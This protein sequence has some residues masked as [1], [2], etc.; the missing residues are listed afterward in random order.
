MNGIFDTH[1][2]YHDAAFDGDR[3]KLLD[4]F[5]E[6]GILGVINCGTD[7]ETSKESLSLSREYPFM[8]AA[9]G[10]HPED[11]EKAYDGYTEDLAVLLAN[12]RAVA[13]GEI[14]LDYHFRD[15][16]KEE[17]KKIFREQ[18]LLANSLGLPVIVHARDAYADTYSILKELRPKGVMHCF[19]GS[20]ESAEEI[21][22]LGMYIG[23]GG[24]VTFKNARKPLEVAAAIPLEKLLIETD[25]PY[26]APV[27]HRGERN[28]SRLLTAVAEKI[29]EA[30]GTSADVIL[31]ATAENANR[32]F[33]T[34]L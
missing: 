17:Q 5:P 29:A 15:D 16:N 28:D 32:L 9:C 34:T 7:I 1:A 18:I 13:V 19:Q 25:C 33:G 24:A 10:V 22:A 3:K 21:I 30:R 12:G 23:L 2:H 14:G 31:K 6:S 27:P 4:S 26:M 11:I 20:R 8:F